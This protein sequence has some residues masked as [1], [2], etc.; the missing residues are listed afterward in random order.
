[1]KPFL[2]AN[3][4]QKSTTCMQNLF[5]NL[6]FNLVYSLQKGEKMPEVLIGFWV[7]RSDVAVSPSE[8]PFEML[9]W[10]IE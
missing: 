6:Y 10:F 4:K 2:N 3:E 5:C 7:I 8:W 1:M 9:E